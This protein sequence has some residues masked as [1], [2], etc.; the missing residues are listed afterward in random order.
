[1]LCIFFIYIPFLIM[2]LNMSSDLI[3][4]AWFFRI[5]SMPFFLIVTNILAMVFDVWASKIAIGYLLSLTG[6]RCVIYFPI[7]CYCRMLTLNHTHVL[8]KPVTCSWSELCW[9]P[10]EQTLAGY[11]VQIFVQGKLVSYWCS[12]TRWFVTANSH[13]QLWWE[14]S[15]YFI[16]WRL[17]SMTNRQPFVVSTF[18]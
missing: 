4:S 6:I 8:V 16:H 7:P 14:S 18:T 11:L 2:Y 13:Q 12:L 15:F 17:K 5:V 9:Y 3:H 10:V 1:M